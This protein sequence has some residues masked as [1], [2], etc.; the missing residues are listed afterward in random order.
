MDDLLIDTFPASAF[1]GRFFFPKALFFFKVPWLALAFFFPRSPDLFFVRFGFLFLAFFIFPFPWFFF[2]FQ[3]KVCALFKVEVSVCICRCLNIR[4]LASN[5]F[6]VD[7][8]H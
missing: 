3:L 4:F 7:F 6:F 8:F 2:L 5:C 1:S